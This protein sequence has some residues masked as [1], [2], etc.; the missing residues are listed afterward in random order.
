MFGGR[1]YD[2]RAAGMVEHT[3]LAP[4][5]Y[6]RRDLI[7]AYLGSFF[8]EPLHTVVHLCRSHRHMYPVSTLLGI[9][10]RIFD[11]Y[12][13][14]RRRR[15][16]QRTAHPRP[17]PLVTNISSPACIRALLPHDG[18]LPWT[19]WQKHR[20]RSNQE[21]KKLHISI[22]FFLF[23]KR[24]TCGRRCRFVRKITFEV[25]EITSHGYHCRIVGGKFPVAADAGGDRVSMQLPPTLP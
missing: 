24:V 3:A 14:P 1:Q 7:H 17:R 25:F 23:L 4:G 12:R 16:A 18:F 10:Q 13:T 15:V 5:A 19:I 6:Q 20:L 9:F 22:P 11:P 21:H 8:E 2:L